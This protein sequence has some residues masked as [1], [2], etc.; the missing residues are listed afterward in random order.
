MGAIG[1]GPSITRSDLAEGT[2]VIVAI[3]H[4]AGHNTPLAA[5]QLRIGPEVRT[6]DQ[7]ADPRTPAIAVDGRRDAGA[8]VVRAGDRDRRQPPGRLGGW[9][10]EVVVDVGRRRLARL[11]VAADGTVRVAIR[12]DWS[13]PG[14]FSDTGILVATDDGSG[15]GT[16]WTYARISEG[17]G[18]D[19][20]RLRPRR[21]AVDRASTV[22]AARSSRG[23]G[24]P[25]PEVP[26]TATGRACGTPP[27]TRT[28]AGRRS[29][30]S[31]STDGV[32]SPDLAIGPDGRRPHR[33]RPLRRR[34]RGRVR[35]DERERVVGETRSRARSTAGDARRLDA[36]RRQRRRPRRRRLGHRPTASSS[37]RG[38]RARGARRRS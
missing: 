30:R 11:A 17:C 29:S 26:S 5:I 23:R 32:A 3:A 16:G 21:D 9:S 4:D 10:R 28:A 34:P 31:P 20:H 22:P 6:I 19:A 7:H 12:A 1:T 15:A 36:D 37:R 25:S 33:V 14:A 2:H 13:N 35:G 38:R 27:N 18:D 24:A 8:R